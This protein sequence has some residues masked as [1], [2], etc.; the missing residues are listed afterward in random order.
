MITPNDFRQ[1]ALALPEA[2]EQEHHSN[3]DFR[4]GGKVF[5]TLAGDPEWGM[6]RLPLDLQATLTEQSPDAFEVIPGAWGK[7]GCTK[8]FLAKVKKKSMR[9]ALRAAWVARAPKR[10]REE[11]EG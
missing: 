1:L 2:T 10:L 8:V 5:A 9:E 4:V 7:Q 6:V 11:F 3:P